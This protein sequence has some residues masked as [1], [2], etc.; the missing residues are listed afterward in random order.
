LKVQYRSPR[1]RH[2]G[3]LSRLTSGG[4]K[5]NTEN[6]GNPSDR[7]DKNKV[8]VAGTRIPLKK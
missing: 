3:K 7:D 5:N 4:S 6:N 2:L 8:R 1:L